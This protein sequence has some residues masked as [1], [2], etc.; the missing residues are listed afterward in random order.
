VFVILFFLSIIF[1]I[2]DKIIGGKIDEDENKNPNI[3][4]F[5]LKIGKNYDFLIDNQNIVCVF[6]K[7]TKKY[8]SLSLKNHKKKTKLLMT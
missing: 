5:I 6:V 1:P 8:N 7:E 3:I 4:K 2:I